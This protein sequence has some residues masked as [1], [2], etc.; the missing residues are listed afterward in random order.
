MSDV[1]SQ[2]RGGKYVIF[3]VGQD[4]KR[5]A[6]FREYTK[7][8]RFVCK[9]LIGTYKAQREVSFIANKETFEKVSHWTV[10]EESLLMLDSAM[11][12]GARPATLI[13]GGHE[14][15][16]GMFRQC[17]Q[18]EAMAQ[19]NWTLDPTTGSYYVCK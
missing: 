5:I 19:E 11:H 7:A 4:A 10:E 8:N 14:T 15:P 2:S 18:S 16:I 9:E 12:D 3:C 13:F 17:N 1:R 6:E